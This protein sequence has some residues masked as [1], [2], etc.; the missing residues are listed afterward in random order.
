MAIKDDK[1]LV[2]QCQSMPDSAAQACL[3]EA[4]DEAI[5]YLQ[6]ALAE[7][8]R[9]EQRQSR[10]DDLFG[11]PDNAVKAIDYYHKE[12][13]ILPGYQAYVNLWCDGEDPFDGRYYKHLIQR[14]HCGTDITSDAMKICYL[15][16]GCMRKAYE[17]ADKMALCAEQ[18]E[19]GLSPSDDYR[20]LHEK[21][22]DSLMA[23]EE[24]LDNCRSLVRDLI[25][26]RNELEERAD[27]YGDLLSDIHKEVS[28]R[29]V[30]LSSRLS[31]RL[32]KSLYS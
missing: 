4:L 10:M 5:V 7:N 26:E 25:F 17:L 19:E 16:S 28:S 14:L 31:S 2:V 20:R 21:L 9:F 23:Y 12:L 6:D 32:K 11:I 15:G 1:E 3:M 27:H 22:N 18:I 13:Q 29:G 30:Q 24:E 8:V